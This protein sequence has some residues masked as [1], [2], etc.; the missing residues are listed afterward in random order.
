MTE[1]KIKVSKL[2]AARRQLEGAIE[3][4]FRDA[5]PIVVHA[6]ISGAYQISQDLNK[7]R[8]N[9]D[10]TLEG[11][12]EVH[13]KPGHVKEALQILRRP[14]NFV[15]HADRDPDDILEFDPGAT[16][17]E[18]LLT[19]HGLRALDGQTSDLQAAFMFWICV[20]RP[21]LILE[22]ENPFVKSLNA[23]QLAHLRQLE[24]PEFLRATLAHLAQ[25]RS[26]R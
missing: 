11:W 8:G 20:N 16:P 7:K 26:K 22:G 19:L 23:A 24:K 14:R 15:K 5:D 25:S 2:D 10:A 13:I 12:A 3:L 21:N 9:K 1:T 6:V 17:Y 18:I 4:W